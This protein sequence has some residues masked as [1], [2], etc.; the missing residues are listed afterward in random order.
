MTL[1]ERRSLEIVKTAN[2]PCNGCRA[3]CMGDAIYLHLECGD[4]PEDYETEQEKNP[5][6][7]ETQYILKHK[8]NNECIYLGPAGCTIYDR[9]P[10]ICREFDCRKL[11]L[12]FTRQQRRLMVRMGAFSKEVLEAGR[13]RLSSLEEK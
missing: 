9:R 7:G 2:A 12:S 10:A 4:R 13:L 5:L 11:F 3:C 1:P 6:T 8:D